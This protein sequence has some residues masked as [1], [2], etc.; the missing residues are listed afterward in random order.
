MTT[1]NLNA[2]SHQWV[3]TLVRFN[4]QLEYQKG[5]DNT[6][7]DALSQITTCLSPKAVQS[8][9]DGV[10]LGMAHRAEGHNPSVFEGDHNV[11][12]EVH[13]ATGQ[14][15]VKM[16]VT[17]WAAAKKEDPDLSA[18]LNWL[19]VQKKTNLRTLL[20]D[21][22]SI[23]EG[24]MVWRNCQNFMT[25]QNALYLRS[26]PKGENEDLL[27]FLVPKAHQIAILNGCH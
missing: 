27:L 11:E 24:Q 26:M 23:E 16:H 12:K 21:H 25:L 22:A 4:F 6:V 5:W 2:T 1:P 8:V 17:N 15:Q 14:V 13:V 18:M 9:L 3:G 19:G 7:A 20:G 10:I